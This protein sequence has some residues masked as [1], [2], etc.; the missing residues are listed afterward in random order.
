M[1]GQLTIDKPGL[2]LWGFGDPHWAARLAQRR[3]RAGAQERYLGFL[4]DIQHKLELLRHGQVF[5]WRLLQPKGGEFPPKLSRPEEWFTGTAQRPPSPR[6]R[7]TLLP[8]TAGAGCPGRHS[9]V[10]EGGRAVAAPTAS[11]ESRF[12]GSSSKMR[13]RP[14]SP[15]PLTLH[16]GK[17][18][19]KG[20]HDLRLFV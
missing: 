1:A 18:R 6:S 3:P 2:G 8:R 19:Q 9:L 5:L 4:G 15:P 13:L 17:L 7:V 20:M 11:R 14:R 12:N 10:P 16:G